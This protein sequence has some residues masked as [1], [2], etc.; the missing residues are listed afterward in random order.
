MA[1]NDGHGSPSIDFL[2]IS[3]QLVDSDLKHNFIW[4]LVN[5]LRNFNNTYFLFTNRTAVRTMINVPTAN[6]ANR[7]HQD[8]WKVEEW[9]SINFSSC[10]T[11]WCPFRNKEKIV[12][13]V[14]R[15]SERV[16]V[17]LDASSLSVTS[18]ISSLL[19][20]KSRYNSKLACKQ[21]SRIFE[22]LACCWFSHVRSLARAIYRWYC[23]Y[24]CF[25]FRDWILF[26]FCWCCG[27]EFFNNFN[28]TRSKNRLTWRRIPIQS[29][30]N[31][32]WGRFIWI[33]Y[34]LKWQIKTFLL[35]YF[36]SVTALWN[37]SV[38]CTILKTLDL[39]I[40]GWPSIRFIARIIDYLT[41]L[42]VRR[43]SQSSHCHRWIQNFFMKRTTRK[44]TRN[45][46]NRPE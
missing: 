12:S 46:I 34:V 32:T 10:D 6:K 37:R 44:W 7:I 28:T 31:V 35:N 26:C 42:V 14:G 23:R 11:G 38:P 19:V 4:V 8:E 16:I 9:S 21:N 18:E 45:R 40:N 15:V 22:I 24:F 17:A 30:W 5:F 27:I 20:S 3:N 36:N 43:W 41:R 39:D 33:T 2:L 25:R 29:S 1:T 13:S